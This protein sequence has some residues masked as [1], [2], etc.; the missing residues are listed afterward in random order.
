M[1]PKPN[2]TLRTLWYVHYQSSPTDGSAV[3]VAEFIAAFAAL[4]AQSG[5]R[6]RVVAPPQ[7]SRAPTTNETVWRK[8]RRALGRYYLRDLL[9]L[10]R[11]WQRSRQEGAQLDADRPDL[12][13]TRYDAET[14]SIHWACH[15]RGIPVVTE[16]NGIDRG[17]LRGTYLDVKPLPWCDRLFSNCH[18]FALSAG[19]LTVT[20]AI[21]APLHR[22]NPDQKPI[23]VNH[24]GVDTTRFHPEIDATPLR[25]QWQ[26]PTETVV[27]GYSGSFIVWHR[28]QRL[29]EAWQRLRAAGHPVALLLIGRHDEAVARRLAELPAHERRWVVW[30][31][32]LPHDAIPQHLAAMDIAV[33]PHTQPYCSPLK[34]F[35]YMAMGKAVVAPDTAG[36]REVL[37]AERE[38]LLFD[39]DDD[40]TFFAALERLVRD[41]PLRHR[42][43]DAARARVE[44]EFT[45]QHNAER[46]WATV[47]AAWQWHHQKARK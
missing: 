3:H 12:V 33:L 15:K 19:A 17:E 34:L 31:G 26:W 18:A 43:G 20:G 5:V 36:V 1:D 27:I 40:S 45:W 32:H 30:T 11:Q 37:T 9:L 29:I 4:C 28:P 38:G 42:L 7:R 47:H 8:V 35:E 10:W 21:A 13:I 23:T 39:P 44:R 24:N 22:C 2:P 25:Q 41:A 6:F 16:F 14:L 46:V